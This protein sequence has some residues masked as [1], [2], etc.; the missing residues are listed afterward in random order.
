MVC[1]RFTR[2]QTL[3]GERRI[4]DQNR[5]RQFVQEPLGDVSERFL[6]ET[7]RDT[8]R[9]HSRDQ[10][11]RVNRFRLFRDLDQQ[12]G[13][14]FSLHQGGNDRIC[15]PLDRLGNRFAPQLSQTRTGKHHLET[16]QTRKTQAKQR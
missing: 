3:I 16:D 4:V 1:D 9:N 6:L 8:L 7:N 15:F 12:A 13:W 11:R 10:R 5:H 2:Q 14:L